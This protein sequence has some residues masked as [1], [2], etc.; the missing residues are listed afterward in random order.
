MKIPRTKKDPKNICKILISARH[1]A[2]NEVRSGGSMPYFKKTT[3]LQCTTTLPK[4]SRPPFPSSFPPRFCPTR[5]RA[6][7][8]PKKHPFPPLSP[9]PSPLPRKPSTIQRPPSPALTTSPLAP[10]QPQGPQ[11]HISTGIKHTS[12]PPSPVPP[13]ASDAGDGSLR[14]ASALPRNSGSGKTRQSF[15]CL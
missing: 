5:D 1:N 4:R 3:T 6:T 10:H 11:H 2:S 8:P 15:F 14:L 12:A 13:H 7:L 9:N